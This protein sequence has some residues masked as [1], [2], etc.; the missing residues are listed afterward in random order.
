MSY[1]GYMGEVEPAWWEKLIKASGEAAAKII[2]AVKGT[3]SYPYG[4][5]AP[6]YFPSGRPVL[7]IQPEINWPLLLGA[8]ALGFLIFN[9]MKKRGR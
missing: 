4:P 1:I 2:P 5:S 9:T 7:P 8:G 6:P 3:P